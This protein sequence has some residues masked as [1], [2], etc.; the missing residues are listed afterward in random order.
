MLLLSLG[1][2]PG[3]YAYTP[4][5]SA[6]DFTTESFEVVWN[7]KLP[8][9]TARDNMIWAKR[10]ASGTYAYGLRTFGDGTF[11]FQVSTVGTDLVVVGGTGYAP[12][13]PL[14]DNTYY[15]F[16]FRYFRATRSYTIEVAPDA[17]TEPTSTWSTVITS[18]TGSP[19]TTFNSTA[20][21][22][23]GSDATG[24]YE[25][26][27]GEIGG[28][29]VRSSHGGA[30]VFS[31]DIENWTGGESWTS[32]T[33]HVVT[34][35]GLSG[36]PATGPQTWTGGIGSFRITATSGTFAG[37]LI[38]EGNNANVTIAGDNLLRDEFGNMITDEDGRPIGDEWL[39]VSDGTGSDEQTWVGNS[40]VGRV[41]QAS[42]T[43]ITPNIWSGGTAIARFTC[44]GGAFGRGGAEPGNQTPPTTTPPPSPDGGS[45]PLASGN[46]RWLKVVF[47]YAGRR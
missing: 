4:D 17:E 14:V 7:M 26:L 41:L 44:P 1:G 12:S 47:G 27:L 45:T 39:F 36:S 31:M 37:G 28:L 40:A 23:V 9:W 21:F 35:P 3:Q 19:L 32:D 11:L 15:W 24:N 25:N 18:G 16:R 42:G 46:Y 6:L 43:F 33:G 20:R 38:W 13:T 29:V 8:D 2:T 30:T 10:G 34:V 5:T 22:T